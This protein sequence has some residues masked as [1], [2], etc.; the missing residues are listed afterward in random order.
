M[1]V[2]PIRAFERG[3]AVLSALNRRGTA[4]V[5]ELARD[6]N[7]PR[8]TVYRA[9]K[10]LIDQGYATLSP[11]DDRITLLLKVRDLSEGF[12]DEQ[13]LGSVA[14]P[15]IFELTRRV[16]WPCDV[17]TLQGTDMVIRETSHRFAPLSIDRGMIGRRLPL[18]NSSAGLAYLAFTS[19]SERT[20][21]LHLLRQAGEIVHA[22]SLEREFRD[23]RKRGFSIRQAGPLWPHTGTIAMPLLQGNRILGCVALIW[24]AKALSATEGIAL[25]AGPLRETVKTIEAGLRSD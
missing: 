22:P 13:W 25:C 12:E 11:S 2:K 21:L 3:L 15:A 20:L 14:A 19:R 23:I 8:A 17:T 24:M 4:S 5:L 18:L 1:D 7:L 6:T 9:L 10:T 16:H